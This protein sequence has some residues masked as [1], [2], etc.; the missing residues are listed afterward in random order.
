[1]PQSYRCYDDGSTFV[2]PSQAPGLVVPTGI[3]RITTAIA[4]HN[5]YMLLAPS[6]ADLYQFLHSIHG[7]TE[8]GGACV[9][10][11]FI[12]QDGSPPVNGDPFDG[13]L[14]SWQTVGSMSRH[15]LQDFGGVPL[16][17]PGGFVLWIGTGNAGTPSTLDTTVVCTPAVCGYTAT[18]ILKS[19][20]PPP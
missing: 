15:S 18:R 14:L 7:V 9:L 16:A 2:V 4:G 6:G 8:N 3:V 13:L 1:M 19:F 20:E 5:P 12:R 10:G 11:Y 17:C